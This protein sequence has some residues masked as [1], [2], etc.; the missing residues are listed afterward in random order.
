MHDDFWINY[1]LAILFGCV[2]GMILAALFRGL[3]VI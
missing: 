1:C 3:G 2:A